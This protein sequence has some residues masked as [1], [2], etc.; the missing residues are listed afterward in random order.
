MFEKLASLTL[1]QCL[2]IIFFHLMYD[3]GFHEKN[4]SAMMRAPIDQEH[5]GSDEKF[6]TPILKRNPY[7][8]N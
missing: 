3:Y 2:Q 1:N 4:I 8:D 5:G 7:L 6:L